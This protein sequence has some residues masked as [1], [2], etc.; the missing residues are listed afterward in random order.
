MN[1]CMYVCMYG[2]TLPDLLG[3]YHPYS[4]IYQAE[5]FTRPLT[6]PDKKISFFNALKAHL[7][8]GDVAR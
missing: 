6:W 3:Q 5:I 7:H 8:G 1:E 2:S 4:R